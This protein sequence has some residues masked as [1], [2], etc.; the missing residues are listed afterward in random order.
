MNRSCFILLSGLSLATLAGCNGSD[1]LVPVS[2]T[3]TFRKQPLET[4]V[5]QFIALDSKSDSF[6]GS[7]SS[8]GRYDIPARQGLKPGK[9][10]VR[11]SSADDKSKEEQAPGDWSERLAKE[12]IPAE[13][14]SRTK[15]VVEIKSSGVNTLD[16][17]VP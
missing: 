8:G 14:N 3:V 1:G 17:D 16:F 13:F 2:G 15:L 6:S 7:V 10:Q 5:V 9:Y 11:I 4:G 12:R